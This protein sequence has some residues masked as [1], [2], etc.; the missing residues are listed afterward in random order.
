[1]LACCW[2]QGAPDVLSFD[3]KVQD[4]IR[5]VLKNYDPSV[6]TNGSTNA[7]PLVADARLLLSFATK[8]LRPS[9]GSS[10]GSSST[11]AEGDESGQASPDAKAIEGVQKVLHRLRKLWEG[12]AA[13][14]EALAQEQEVDGGDAPAPWHHLGLHR[15]LQ[16]R[17]EEV[18]AMMMERFHGDDFDAIDWRLRVHRRMQRREMMEHDAQRQARDRDDEQRLLLRRVLLE[19]ISTNLDGANVEASQEQAGSGPSGQAAG[20]TP[21]ADISEEKLGARVEQCAQIYAEYNH[22]KQ[23][24]ARVVS[25]RHAV[26][27]YQPPA[28][29]LR[30]PHL[31][32]HS[33]PLGGVAGQASENYAPLAARRAAVIQ[34]LEHLR[35]R[36]LSTMARHAVPAKER[37]GQ[38]DSLLQRVSSKRGASGLGRDAGSPTDVSQDDELAKGYAFL[39]AP[40]QAGRKDAAETP[41]GDAAL[42]SAFAH[43]RRMAEILNTTTHLRTGHAFVEKEG[44]D[45]ED[46]V[47]ELPQ[48]ASILET[49]LRMQPPTAAARE[50]RGSAAASLL[51]AAARIES[52]KRGAASSQA[53]GAGAGAAAGE[54]DARARTASVKPKAS[55]AAAAELPLPSQPADARSFAWRWHCQ[56]ACSVGGGRNSIPQVAGSAAA[57]PGQ[58][59]EANFESLLGASRILAEVR[60]AL[61]RRGAASACSTTAPEPEVAAENAMLKSLVLQAMDLNLA[62]LDWSMCCK[63]VALGQNLG[64]DLS[65][66]IWL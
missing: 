10:K 13:M 3:P 42:Q 55:P 25:V 15:R 54:R 20:D 40:S 65:R 24:K 22:I 23:E 17:R 8:Y 50:K 58:V 56:Q 60:E 49:P 7:N 41:G 59:E 28:A 64:L 66:C 57:A 31:Q 37:G 44:V 11:K 52:R 21:R 27:C 6:E 38:A 12:R 9:E 29:A 51:T 2:V 16:R 1:M 34:Q 18:H 30:H 26:A 53:T 36:Q 43:T 45:E 5:R 62:S 47:V 33:S 61:P 46:E 35:A 19:Q 14:F 32:R 63:L 4:L 48:R 39:E